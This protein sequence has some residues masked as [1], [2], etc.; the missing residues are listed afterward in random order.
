MNS[1]M[2]LFTE[3]NFCAAKPREFWNYFALFFCGAKEPQNNEQKREVS[4]FATQNR[5][6]HLVTDN[7]KLSNTHH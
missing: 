7:V 2:V 4:D 5:E 6:P 3:K 1:V